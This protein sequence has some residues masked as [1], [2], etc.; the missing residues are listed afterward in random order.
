MRF[1]G[2]IAQEKFKIVNPFKILVLSAHSVNLAG[3]FMYYAQAHSLA[4]SKM[5]SSQTGGDEKLFCIMSIYFTPQK[6][7]T[8]KINIY[9]F[10]MG[11]EI[12]LW[13][14]RWL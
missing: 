1:G 3:S 11:I 7:I 8:V 9:V 5:I 6:H 2:N 13:H 14:T 10:Y 4:Y 12:R